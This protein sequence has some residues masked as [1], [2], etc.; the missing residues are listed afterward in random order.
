MFIEKKKHGV[1]F[2]DD[3]DKFSWVKSSTVDKF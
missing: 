1:I 2:M 3:E